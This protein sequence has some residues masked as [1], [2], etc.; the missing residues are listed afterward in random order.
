[1]RPHPARDHLLLPFLDVGCFIPFFGVIGILFS[2]WG[3]CSP[4]PVADGKSLCSW[5]LFASAFGEIPSLSQVSEYRTFSAL[6]STSFC[7]SLA[8]VG[9]CS[10]TPYLTFLSFS[11]LRPSQPSGLVSSFSRH[12]GWSPLFHSNTSG[13]NLLTIQKEPQH[14]VC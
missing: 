2:C 5:R 13:S 8:S 6:D 3:N 1:M 12:L 7:L 4:C 10:A 11:W 9:F 14:C